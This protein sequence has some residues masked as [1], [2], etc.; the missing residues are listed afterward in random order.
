MYFTRWSFLLV[1]F[2]EEI[3]KDRAG[4]IHIPLTNEELYESG[5]G[6]VL[7]LRILQVPP[8]VA[9]SIGAEKL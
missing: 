4:L 1:A 9:D 6:S 8:S 2:L 3:F 5:T 7:N